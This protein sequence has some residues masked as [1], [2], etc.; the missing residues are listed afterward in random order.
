MSGR[1][2]RSIGAFAAGII[3]T[4][5]LSY[6]TDY[7]LRV[8]GV[9]PE[10][11]FYVAWFLI[12]PVILY[13]TIYN[14]IGGY[15]VATLAPGHPVGHAVAIGVLGTIGS[16]GGAVATWN[17]HVGPHWYPLTL[18]VLSLPATWYGGNLSRRRSVKRQ[19]DALRLLTRFD[20]AA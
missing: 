2:F 20:S 10:K 11:T 19:A 18:A 4:F 17:V 9:L 1:M 16:I 5:G 14:S 12:V 3:V 15:V 13:R 7:V 6:G 8:V